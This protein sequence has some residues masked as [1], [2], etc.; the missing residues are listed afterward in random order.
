M[1]QDQ[2][3]GFSRIWGETRTPTGMMFSVHSRKDSERTLELGTSTSAAD[4]GTL[5]RSAGGDAT[6]A[7]KHVPCE[8]CDRPKQPHDRRQWAIAHAESFRDVVLMDVNF[9][10][11]MEPNCG[12]KRRR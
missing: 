5:S 10:K 7:V 1:K 6:E 2:F 3:L 12:G 11:L 8:V 4:E 9:W